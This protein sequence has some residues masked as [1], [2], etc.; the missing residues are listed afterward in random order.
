MNN[1]ATPHSILNHIDV[2]KTARNKCLNDILECNCK[3][4]SQFDISMPPDFDIDS[5][6]YAVPVSYNFQQ[7]VQRRIPF[8]SVIFLPH[9]H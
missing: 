8:R 6:V 2:L 4:W 7:T 9:K 3:D 5:F 1:A